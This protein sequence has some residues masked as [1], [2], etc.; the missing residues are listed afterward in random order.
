V[1]LEER[2]QLATHASL[3]DVSTH[4]LGL[5]GRAATSLRA[6][7][8]AVIGNLGH[9]LVAAVAPAAASRRGRRWRL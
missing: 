7:V 5:W 3:G 8:A 6:L 1:A 4:L 2:A 9:R